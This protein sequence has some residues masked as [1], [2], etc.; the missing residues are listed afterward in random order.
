MTSSAPG[1]SK[2]ENGGKAAAEKGPVSAPKKGVPSSSASSKGAEIPAG[3][4]PVR[5]CHLVR[6]PGFDGYGF[7]VL[8]DEKDKLATVTYVEKGG[9]AEAGGLRAEECIVL[10]NGV[11]V[12]GA[13]QQDVVERIKSSTAEVDLLVTSKEAVAWYKERGIAFSSN[14]PNVIRPSGGTAAPRKANK[15]KGQKALAKGPAAES[16]AQR[17]PSMTLSSQ[18]MNIE[19]QS[20]SD[21]DHELFV[22]R[23]KGAKAAKP[24]KPP[25]KNVKPLAALGPAATMSKD[26]QD[27][28]RKHEQ[29][30]T[31]T[32]KTEQD[33]NSVPG[34]S[35][36][37]G[38]SVQW[39]ETTRT[40]PRT[41]R[42]RGGSGRSQVR[43][44]PVRSPEATGS[45][46]YTY[47]S[48]GNDYEAYMEGY[49]TDQE[50]GFGWPEDA[51]SWNAPIPFAASYGAPPAFPPQ[52]EALTVNPYNAYMPYHPQG[53]YWSQQIP[54]QEVHVPPVWGPSYGYPSTYAPGYSD[55]FS[56][57][58]GYASYE[59]LHQA[60]A[61]P[62]R[63]ET[64]AAIRPAQER[65]G[66]Q[67]SSAKSTTRS[68]AG[69]SSKTKSKS[70]EAQGSAPGGKRGEKQDGK[71]Q[72]G[73][74]TTNQA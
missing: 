16:L 3:A 27:L 33:G 57:Y 65:P 25:V 37:R 34:P 5:Q 42:G 51:Y 44:L 67:A 28:L 56:L 53:L 12:I 43:W 20:S 11:N 60:S 36:G 71:K 59:P 61:S 64:R 63:R 2:K 17:R 13:S 70:N 30:R 68:S 32:D 29:A 10:V 38:A 74:K 21:I 47:S 35:S 49:M 69:T 72:D 6:R 46:P 7:G 62:E 58:P 9:P 45:P 24:T 39:T 26:E 22:P 18:I 23:G 54:Y 15:D 8:V 19:E 41:P 4:P 50:D 14:M 66:S 1:S 73:K 48:Q 31:A 55:F 40:E 52:Y